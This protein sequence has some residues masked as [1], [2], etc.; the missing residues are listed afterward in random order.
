M[1]VLY[2]GRQE[3]KTEELLQLAAKEQLTLVLIN[4]S[5]C[6][7]VKLRASELNLSIRSPITHSDFIKGCGCGKMFNGFLIDNADMLIQSMTHISVVAI[8]VNKE[9]VC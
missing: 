8:S 6:V 3:G 9:D 2:K 7:R 4:R 1:L 5:E